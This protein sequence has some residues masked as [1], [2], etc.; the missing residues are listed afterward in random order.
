[1]NDSL[2]SIYM[3][4]PFEVDAVQV[5]EENMEAVAKWCQGDVRLERDKKTGED[6]RYIKVRV[7]KPANERQTK[8]YVG[9]W[10]LYA[11]TGYKTYHDSAFHKNFEKR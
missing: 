2:T 8:A 1:M 3:R 5:T 10:V 4:R 11:G 7:F 9:H 6:V